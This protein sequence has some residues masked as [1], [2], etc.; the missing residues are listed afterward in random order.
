MHPLADF[1]LEGRHVRLEPL[2]VRHVDALADVGT[3]ARIWEFSRT[4]LRNRA[5]VESYVAKALATREAGTAF[6]FATIECAS[7]RVVGST[8]FENIEPGERRVEV[9]WSWLA[10]AWWRTPFNTEAKYLMLRHAFE[11]WRCVRVVPARLCGTA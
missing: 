5:D 7:G 11:Q 8:R 1:T 6:P 10:P 4:L 3:D 2:T 9:G